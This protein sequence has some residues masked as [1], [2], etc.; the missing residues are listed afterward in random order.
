MFKFVQVS[1]RESYRA[2]IWTSNALFNN[3]KIWILQILTFKNSLETFP[4]KNQNFLE[5][6]S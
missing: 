6:H 5:K 2:E 4:K 3:F 1:L